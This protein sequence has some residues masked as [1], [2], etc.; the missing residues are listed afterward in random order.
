[1]PR[2]VLLIASGGLGDTVLLSL[3]TDRFRALAG[4]REPVRLLLNK[5]AEKMAFL[6]PPEIAVDS[7]DLQRLRRD[8]AYRRRTMAALYDANYRLVVHTDYLRHPD[9]DEALILAA[10]AAES[11]AME[12]R[13][14]PKYDAALKANRRA[15]ARLFESGPPRRDKVL[16]WH[17]FADWLLGKT[18]TPPA[19]R[20]PA[21]RLPPVANEPAP[22]V[23]IQPFSAVP[24][25]Q[26]PPDL[27]G[28]IIDT[29]PAGTQVAVAGAP[30]DRQRNPGYETLL[31]RAN[32]SFEDATFEAL[33]PRL[34]AA[35]LV[36]S[37]DT[38]CMHLAAALGAPTLCLA[39]AAYVGEIVPYAP[40]ITPDNVRFLYESMPCEGCLGDCL[41]PAEGGMYPCVARLD[42]RAVL[43]TVGE[44]LDR[45]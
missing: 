33:A 28:K 37:V 39:S 13:P 30:S 38:A 44:M 3:V 18:T 31:A 5:G 10:A 2:G 35:K 4:P 42:E 32:V 26:S 22:L 40:E 7:V 29:L 6:L 25:K 24:E 27:Y 23:V 8:L 9:M 41:L 1:M 20:L 14:W 21:D 12:P 16:R 17:A 34:R 11:V 15:Y 45:V 36:I 43:A 19:V